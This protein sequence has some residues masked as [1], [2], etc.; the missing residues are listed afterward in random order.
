MDGFSLVNYN[1]KKGI[2]DNVYLWK[3]TIQQFIVYFYFGHDLF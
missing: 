3:L 1:P 2:L